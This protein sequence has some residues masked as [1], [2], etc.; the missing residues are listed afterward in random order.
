MIRKEEIHAAKK[1]WEQARASAALAHESYALLVKS[2][3][4]LLHSYRTAGFPFNQAAQQ[5]ESLIE[6]Y[7]AR[8]KLALEHMDAMA[9]EHRKLLEEFKKMSS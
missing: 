3:R 7:A 4:T 2:H 6:E 5:F 8:Y 9:E 1:L